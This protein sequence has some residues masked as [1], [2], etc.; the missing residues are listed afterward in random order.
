MY[1]IIRAFSGDSPRSWKKFD[2]SGAMSTH[3]L[4]S[5]APSKVTEPIITASSG[6]VP[7]SGSSA[8]RPDSGRRTPM[9]RPRRSQIEIREKRL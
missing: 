8:A 4:P 1:V 7:G 9:S 5:A 3:G 2:M 6:T